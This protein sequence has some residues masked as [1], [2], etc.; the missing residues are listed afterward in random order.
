M[1]IEKD[2]PEGEGIELEAKTENLHQ[3]TEFVESFLDNVGCPMKSLMQINIAVDE[4][5]TNISSYAYPSGTGMA[6]IEVKMEDD[7]RAV[8]ITFTDSGIPYDPLAKDDPDVTLSVKER[9]IGGLGI[10]MAKKLMDEITYA[11]R[12]GKNI[13]TMK[14]FLQ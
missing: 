4:I 13:L 8:L 9:Q 5:F 10:F 2:L 3:A 1:T 6:K 12:D 11:Y 14:K 7:P